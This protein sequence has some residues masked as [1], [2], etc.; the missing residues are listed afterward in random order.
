MSHIKIVNHILPYCCCHSTLSKGLESFWE[1]QNGCSREGGCVMTPDRNWASIC[2]DRLRR[3][4]N[5]ITKGCKS[6]FCLTTTNRQR[7]SYS[8]Q[9]VRK[10][11]PIRGAIH[12][13]RVRLQ[14]DFFVLLQKV[15]LSLKG[16]RLRAISYKTHTLKVTLYPLI[17]GPPKNMSLEEF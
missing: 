15:N 9:I 16:E 4:T 10:M 12:F 14:P 17:V 8:E 7:I 3:G 2:P 11:S 5:Q 13:K 6:L 1:R